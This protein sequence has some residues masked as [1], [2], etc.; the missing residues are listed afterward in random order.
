M[1]KRVYEIALTMIPG[2]GSTSCRKLLDICPDPAEI[3]ALPM[4]K[5]REL[6]GMH[7]EIAEAIHSKSSVPRAEEELAYADRYHIQVLFYTDDAFPRRLNRAGCTDAPVLLYQHGTC[8]LNAERSLAVVGSRRATAHGKEATRRIIEGLGGESVC[9]VSGLAYGIDTAAHDAALEYGLPTVAVLGH[10]L[11]RIYP[12]QNRSLAQRIVDQGGALV[13]E[14]A[15]RT[16]INAGNFPAR[17]RIIAALGDGTLVVESA[18]K[19]GAL[20]TAS[21]AGS[22]NREV[23]AVP[24]RPTD[25]YSAGCNTLIVAQRAAMVR[26]ADDL[27]EVMGWSRRAT[28]QEGVQVELYPVLDPSEQRIVTLLT[29]RDTMLLDELAACCGLTLPRAAAMLLEMELRGLIQALPGGRY[30]VLRTK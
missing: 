6:F 27:M 10:G 20:I 9:V 17:N 12:P 22:Y 30:Q 28:T 29:E 15:S 21:I 23:M 3:F 25:V 7:A 14:F 8:D 26:H 16:S 13:T 18:K 1:D 24:G 11:D 5:L 19:G 4:S 2:L